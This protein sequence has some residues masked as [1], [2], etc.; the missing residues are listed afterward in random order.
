MNGQ[1]DDELRKRTDVE[2]D[3]WKMVKWTDEW[4]NEKMNKQFKRKNERKTDGW[5]DE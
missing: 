4:M 3:G 2:K 5:M 1:T